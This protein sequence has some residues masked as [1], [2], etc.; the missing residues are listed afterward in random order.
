MFTRP[1]AKKEGLGMRL[2]YSE[3]GHGVKSIKQLWNSN[4]SCLLVQY[5]VVVKAIAVSPLF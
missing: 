2:V 3:L 5:V 4:P 1:H